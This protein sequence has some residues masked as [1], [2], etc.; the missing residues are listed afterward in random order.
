M[1]RRIA[2]PVAIR[3]QSVM[4]CGLTPKKLA[5][6]LCIG[7]ALGIMPLLWGTTLICMALAHLLRL[8]QVALQSVNYLFYPLQLALLVPFFKL[9]GWLFPWGPKIPPNVLTTLI[10]NPGLSSLNILGW[11]TLKSLFAW[12]V[13]ALPVALLAYVILRVASGRIVDQSIS[14]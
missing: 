1:L 9:G 8:N 11:I 2:S 10:K 3:L 13:T 6:T 12:L 7:S 14:H 4:T 5:L